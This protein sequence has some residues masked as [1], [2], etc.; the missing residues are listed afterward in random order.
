LSNVTVFGGSVANTL[1]NIRKRH[2]LADRPL[3][4]WDLILVM[5]PLTI[6]GA[7]AGAFLNKVLP[8]LLLTVLLV[9]LLSFTAYTTLTKAVKMY[10]A[11]TKAMR[12]ANAGG[13]SKES[14]LTRMTANEFATSEEEAA[15]KLLDHAEEIINPDEEEQKLNEAA[16]AA[17]RSD[18]LEQ[19]LE[20]EKTPPVANVLILTAMF[21]VVLAINVLKGGGA[22]PS[23]LGIKCGSNSFWMANLIMFLWI[24]IIGAFVRQFLVQKYKAK[25]RC[26]FKYVEGDIK[27]D[28]RATIVYPFVCCFAG[29]FAGMFGIVRAHDVDD[30]DCRDCLLFVVG[31]V[32]IF[33]N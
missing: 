19:I 20:V 1:L 18:E 6:A 15:E 26:G 32:E 7:L 31:D 4:D 17:K 11:E 2:P 29:F 21:V 16:A 33:S 13:G 23:P 25:E 8:E 9:L 12:K 30:D 14:E 27:W 10:K 28:G 5:E 3:I 22:F 24:L